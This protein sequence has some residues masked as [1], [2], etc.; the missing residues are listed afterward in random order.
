MKKTIFTLATL[1]ILILPNVANA[2]YDVSSYHDNAEAIGY[3]KNQKIVKGYADGTFKADNKINRAEFTKIIIEATVDQNEIKGSACFSDIKGE[4]FAKYVCTAKTRAIING[5]P[6]GT[7]KPERDISFVEA[8]KII[9]VAFGDQITEDNQTWYKP[10]VEN[11]GDKKAI[12]I[13]VINL[14][15]Q[16]TRGEMAEMIYRIKAK[17]K[18]KESLSY[19]ELMPTSKPHV[20]QNTEADISGNYLGS[21]YKGNYVWGGAMNLAW[22][23]LGENILHE[24]LNLKTDDKIAL[25]MVEKLNNPTFTKNDLDE[26]S[27]YVKSGYGQDTVDLINKES[28]EKFPAKSFSDLD[29]NLLQTEIIS[30]AYFLKEVEYKA[31]F[32]KKDFSF[33]GEEVEGFYA[34]KELQREN[35]QIIKYE[36]DDKFIVKLRLKDSDDELILAKGYDMTNPQEIVEE[37]NQNN[38]GSLSIIEESDRFE[39]PILHL[40]HSRDYVELV[41]KFLANQGFEEYFIAQMFENIK[42]DMDE[43]GARVENEAGIIMATSISEPQEPRNFIM[44]KSYWVVMKRTDSENP[45]FILGVNNTELM[46]KK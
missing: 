30:Y 44:D 27:Y 14:S 6:D 1:L 2:F 9:S 10:Y 46:E 15:H 37:I 25:E 24:E 33:N 29:I 4:W 12:P 18:N 36:N 3:I 17:V 31:V 11:L 7:F 21:D 23:E 13:S 35:V 19:N 38:K 45:Y 40:D 41:R 26:K 5:Y 43:K 22:S 39:A 8:A 34:K 20:I 28:R 16:I 42:F 32:E